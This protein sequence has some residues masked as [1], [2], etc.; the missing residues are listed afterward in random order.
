MDQEQNLQSLTGQVSQ[1]KSCITR[2]ADK[3]D[4]GL[5]ILEEVSTDSSF[6]QPSFEVST[7]PDLLEP[8]FKGY[9]HEKTDGNSP[10]L[11]S[12]LNC[13]GFNTAFGSPSKIIPFPGPGL[14]TNYSDRGVSCNLQSER[15]LHLPILAVPGEPLNLSIPDYRPHLQ[16]DGLIL[17]A[18]DMRLTEKGERFTA[19]WVTSIGVSRYYASKLLS[20]EDFAL[21]QPDHK[22]YAAE[23]GIEFYGQDAPDYL[24]HIAPEL[25]MSNPRHSELRSA[26]IDTLKFHGSKVNFDYKFLLK[27]QKNRNLPLKKSNDEDQNQAGA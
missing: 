13:L 3:L 10:D 18:W 21:A 16:R 8:S 19:Y 22:S 24:V 26:H 1:L 23:D 14:M 4:Q 27:T 5:E 12:A 2:M 25:M 20:A 7:E 9:N 15:S 17:L 11:S 6:I